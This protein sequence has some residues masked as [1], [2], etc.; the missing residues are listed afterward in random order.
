MLLGHIPV[1]LRWVQSSQ[2]VATALTLP[3]ILKLPTF[4]RIRLLKKVCL[5]WSWK[6]P[7]LP[8]RKWGCQKD[9]NNW[10][11][12]P[13][14]SSCT[15]GRPPIRSKNGSPGYC[16]QKVSSFLPSHMKSGRLI[17]GSA[18][19]FQGLW[20]FK[21]SKGM[22]WFLQLQSV[23]WACSARLVWDMFIQCLHS[24]CLSRLQLSRV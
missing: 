22:Q 24:S 1:C 4:V 5:S 13:D 14:C 8:G 21:A 11:W 15:S 16:W 6:M 23:L 9:R 7:F 19:K 3:S 2:G 17:L 20:G 18:S 10:V 12:P